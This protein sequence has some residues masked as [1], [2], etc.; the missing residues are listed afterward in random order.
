MRDVSRSAVVGGLRE[1]KRQARPAFYDMLNTV[2]IDEEDID[3]GEVVTAL[4]EAHSRN[5]WNRLQPQS[6][7]RTALGDAR[8]NRTPLITIIYSTS[9]ENSV[10]FLEQLEEKLRDP[11]NM[12]HTTIF[13]SYMVDVTSPMYD[14]FLQ[15]VENNQSLQDQLSNAWSPA[16]NLPLV[17]ILVPI[18]GGELKLA[19]ML[20]GNIRT[21]E[22]FNSLLTIIAEHSER[23]D[24]ERA[25]TAVGSETQQ[26]QNEI[27]TAL[28]QAMDEDA[29]KAKEE[30][31]KREAAARA[32][33]EEEA[34]RKKQE[35]EARIKK[36]RVATRRE[37]RLVALGIEPEKS[38]ETVDIMFRLPN[39]GST[40]R[41]FNID[42]SLETVYWLLDLNEEIRSQFDD[43]DECTL[44]MSYP[45][46]TLSM[47][48]HGACQLKDLDLTGMVAL[49]VHQ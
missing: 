29:R 6:D 18:S 10:F 24:V 39:G 2:C 1:L 25:A 42:D 17:A 23:L 48:E 8:R 3:Q 46:K 47:A 35:E 9:N 49:Q 20:H 13:S 11:E 33:R 31:E 30:Q 5:V 22:F 12:G 27:S 4:G 38:K 43:T 14:D 45:K 26:I 28:Q 15:V 41:R 21:D 34:L 7:I 32:V 19:K 37:A 36:E 40:K 44:V 16:I